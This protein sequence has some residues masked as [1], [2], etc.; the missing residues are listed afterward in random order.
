MIICLCYNNNNIIII[1][2]IKFKIKN[3]MLM[4]RFIVHIIIRDREHPISNY[5]ARGVA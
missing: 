4:L 5:G 3:N 1:I 2:I